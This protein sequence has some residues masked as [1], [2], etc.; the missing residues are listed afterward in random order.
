[1]FNVKAPSHRWLTSTVFGIG[2]ASLFSDLSHETVTSILPALLASMGV[3]AGAL[4]TIEGVADGV[5]SIAKLYGGWLT[6]RL[7]RRKPLCAA[8][9]AAMTF[10]TGVIATAT[11]WP[12]VMIGRAAAW[13]SRG[14]R[15]APRKT[16]LAD[17]VTP[18]TYGRA[19]GFERMMDTTGAV[20]APL[21][22]MTLLRWGLSLRTLM[23]L[24]VIPAGLAAAAIIFLVR[25][26]KSH[27]PA[28]RPLIGSLRALPRSF[29]RFMKVVG[30]FG[31]GD[32]AHSLMILY[33]VLALSPEYGNARA[34]VMATGFYALHNVV[35]AAVSYP[36]GSLADRMNTY[37]LLGAGYA[38]GAVTAFLLMFQI[39]DPV[40][41]AV[42]FAVGGIYVGIEETL[43][44][45]LA[46][47][48]LPRDLRGTG[49]GTLAL[50]N[51]IGD[52]ISSLAVG[53]LWTAFGPTIGFSFAFVLMAAGTTGVLIASRTRFHL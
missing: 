25:E 44:D 45:S 2:V 12:V 29:T 37:A 15:T 22:A 28:R 50:V 33:A 7:S 35:Y 4:G 53:W 1:M 31:A 14:V 41:L 30:V 43:E 51:G 52:S 19:F 23:W 18:E 3:A 46:A 38:C 9:Y 42:A 49:F 39:R 10:A 20:V 47:E 17:S 11:A 6:D 5:S 13:F 16:L 34:S 40:L 21:A 8:G 36:A 32:F 26:S 24:S 27:V 48:L